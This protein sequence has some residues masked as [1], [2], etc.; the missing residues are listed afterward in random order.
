[1]NGIRVLLFLSLYV[2]GEIEF[3]S[4]RFNSPS[5]PSYLLICKV[6]LTS[7]IDFV[8][9]KFWATFNPLSMSFSFQGVSHVHPQYCKV[10][11]KQQDSP[12]IRPLKNF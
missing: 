6:Y 5:M 8:R 2:R 12:Y 1:M 11:G 10:S 9:I 3:F 7:E 4:P